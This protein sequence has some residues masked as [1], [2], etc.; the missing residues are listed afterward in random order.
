VRANVHPPLTYHPFPPQDAAER[1][2][3]A[4]ARV[5]RGARRT[6]QR[7]QGV[8]NDILEINRYEVVRG[9]TFCDLDQ[10]DVANVVIIGSKV[11]GS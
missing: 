1:V 7:V 11:T 5:T 4:L 6:Y 8:E 10:R 9:R 3:C 2:E